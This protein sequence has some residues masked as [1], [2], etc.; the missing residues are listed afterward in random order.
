[1]CYQRRKATT[2]NETSI[3]GMMI[4]LSLGASFS[5]RCILIHPKIENIVFFGITAFEEIVQTL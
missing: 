1:M 5:E 4:L 3:G 2:I